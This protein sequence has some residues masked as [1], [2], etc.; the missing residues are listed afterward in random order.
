MHRNDTLGC[1]CLDV[2][3]SCSVGDEVDQRHACFRIGLHVSGGEATQ[4][5][6][7]SAREQRE[8]RQPEPSVPVGSQRE[9]V[10]GEY[11]RVE[12]KLQLRN[13]KRCA[14]GALLGQPQLAERISPSNI[15]GHK[16]VIVG[17]DAD[18]LNRAK[19]LVYGRGN[20]PRLLGM[21]STPSGLRRKRRVQYLTF[22]S[23]GHVLKLIPILQRVLLE[24]QRYGHVAVELHEHPDA[25]SEL[26]NRAYRPPPMPLPAF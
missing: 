9:L 19:L 6:L 5:R 22:A 2:L 20:D 10:L 15:V 3:A 14:L 24:D 16:P 12:K 1:I 21:L 23:A 11:R 8:H 17:P 25:A 4:L 7:A 26:V 13:L 18:R